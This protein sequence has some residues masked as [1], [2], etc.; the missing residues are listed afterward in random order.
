MTSI[1]LVPARA[2]DLS[3]PVEWLHLGLQDSPTQ[4]FISAVEDILGQVTKP[5]RT[6]RWGAFWATRSIE[7]RVRAVGL[8]C[9]KK[10]PNDLG[11]VEIAYYTFPHREGRGIATAMVRELTFCASP[12]VAF[13]I[14]HTLPVENA[15]CKVLRRCGYALVGE[16]IDPEDGLVW[17]WQLPV[18]LASTRRR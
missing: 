2:D 15:S 5:A 16:A 6:E 4:N 12:H 3:F 7:G 18:V 9:Y 17:R 1:Q 13:V 8:C 11:E 10:E 14:A